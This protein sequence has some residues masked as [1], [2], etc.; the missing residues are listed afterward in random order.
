MP[1]LRLKPLVKLPSLPVIRKYPEPMLRSPIGFGYGRL[2]PQRPTVVRKRDL[3]KSC[4][5]Y[6][7][8]KHCLGVRC[9]W[10][11]VGT[12]MV[13]D[14]LHARTKAGKIAARKHRNGK[15]GN[16]KRKVGKK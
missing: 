8:M 6:K 16:S 7:G 9:Y 3:V 5:Y 12:C 11:I 10:P 1:S 13:Y 2:E 15:N 14:K 4:F